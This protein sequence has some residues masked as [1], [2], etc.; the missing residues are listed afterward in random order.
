ME[1]SQA[2]THE[3]LNRLQTEVNRLNTINK[4]QTEDSEKLVIQVIHFFIFS[5]IWLY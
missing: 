3:E 5:S 2:Q 4:Q 1:L